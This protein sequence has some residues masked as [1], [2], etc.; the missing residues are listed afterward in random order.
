M[1]ERASKESKGNNYIK[2]VSN[3]LEAIKRDNYCINQKVWFNWQVFGFSNYGKL[4]SIKMNKRGQA[5]EG[6]DLF[7]F[8]FFLLIIGGGIFAGTYLFFGS[9]SD[10][11]EIEAN[12]LANRVEECIIDKGVNWPND[13]GFYKQCGLNKIV[14]NEGHTL[15]VRKINWD[16]TKGEN[17][18][19]LGGNFEA[20][21]FIGVKKNKYYPKCAK[22]EVDVE[23]EKYEIVAGSNQWLK[24]RRVSG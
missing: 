10:F 19:V 24:K 13:D 8:M 5:A 3:R 12:Q 21:D 4:K 17:K 22:R 16:N 9:E 15:V 18:F 1:G 7:P 23:G 20:C 14:L 11:R 6:L 2:G